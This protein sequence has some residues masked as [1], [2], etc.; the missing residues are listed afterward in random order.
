MD[1]KNYRQDFSIEALQAG[2]EQVFEV[3]FRKFYKP[4]CYF[5][6]RMVKNQL[7]AE[8]IAEESFIKLWNRIEQFGNISHIKHFLYKTSRNSCLDYLKLDQ[9]AGLREKA[10]ISSLDHYDDHFFN[11]MI[12]AEVL[13]ELY[14][15][16]RQL[17][18]QCRK[19]VSM[20]YIDGLKNS[21]IAEK[22]DISIQTV[23]NQKS[24]G[25]KILQNQFS[26]Y[27]S[28]LVII[29]LYLLSH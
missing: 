5:A 1:E 20:S 12:R 9:R 2:D 21:K 15:A 25:L 4:L 29:S 6:E 26:K 10:F 23:K 18:A 16:I 8:D 28:F 7:V 3:L 14:E 22:L 17:P 24:R 13:G 27:S 19:I 11:E